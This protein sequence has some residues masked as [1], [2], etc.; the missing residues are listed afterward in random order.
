MRK[1]DLVAKPCFDEVSISGKDCLLEAASIEGYIVKVDL[2][3]ECYCIKS[4][5]VE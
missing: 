2:A 1:T 4:S 3:G 5:V